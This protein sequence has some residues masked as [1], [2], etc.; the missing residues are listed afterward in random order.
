M[1]SKS[2]FLLLLILA[3][4][5]ASPLTDDHARRSKFH[6]VESSSDRGRS[7]A[8][9]AGAVPGSVDWR[10]KGVVSPVHNQGPI[11]TGNIFAFLDVLESFY[12]I[13]HQDHLEIASEQE[14]MDCCGSQGHFIDALYSCVLDHGGL[15]SASAYKAEKGVCRNNTCPAIFKFKHE[16]HVL[17]YS[18]QALEQAV[19]Q[20]PVLV[21]IDASS[22]AFQ[23]YNSGVFSNDVCRGSKS[24]DHSMLAVGYGQTEDGVK[25]WILKNSWGKSCPTESY[26]DDLM[27][28]KY[29]WL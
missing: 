19:A 22:T 27:K 2:V 12:A 14:L 25:Y 10:T 24:L 18:E 26:M 13:H 23:E 20:L 16:V 6:K 7:R 5:A 21:A 15:C 29:Y 17:R 8:E 28:G 1:E 4:A 3:V 11:A 9:H